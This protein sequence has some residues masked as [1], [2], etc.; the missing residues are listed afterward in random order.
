MCSLFFKKNLDYGKSHVELNTANCTDHYSEKFDNA[1][2]NLPTV[3][4]IINIPHENRRV[5]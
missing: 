4:N 1:P 2:E 3:L 5:L